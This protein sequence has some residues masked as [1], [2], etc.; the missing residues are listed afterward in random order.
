MNLK[1]CIFLDR[2]GV[3]NIERGAYTFNLGDFKL[4]YNI[5]ETINILKK[6]DYLLVVITNQA[7]IAK[8]LYTK[9]EVLACHHKLQNACNH[10]LDALYYS[11]YHPN[12]TES[13]SRKPG[14]LMFEKAISRFGIDTKSSFMVGDKVRDLIP[15]KKLG[16]KTVL[17]NGDHKPIEADFLFKNLFDFSQELLHIQK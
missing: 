16:I 12:F 11:P 10:Q 14:S 8:G 3:L 1:K 7:G 5:A 15:A 6:H 9:Q 13:L 17:V 4:E 2:D